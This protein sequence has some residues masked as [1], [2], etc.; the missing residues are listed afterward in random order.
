MA[1]NIPLTKIPN[2]KFSILLDDVQYGIKIVTS[3]GISLISIEA[4]GVMLIENTRCMPNE[5]ILYDYQK[6]G[7]QFYWLS[8]DDS[9]PVYTGFGIN[10]FLIYKSDNE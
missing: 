5:S 10:Y 2:Q 4:E 9:Y 6:K 3:L 8:K 7:G 1:S